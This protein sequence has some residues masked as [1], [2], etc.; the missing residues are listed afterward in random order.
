[1]NYLDSNLTGAFEYIVASGPTQLA[2]PFGIVIN[3]GILAWGAQPDAT[4]FEVYIT[5]YASS[6]VIVAGGTYSLDLT[7]LGLTTG[8][9]DITIVA[10]GDGEDFTDSE[11]STVVQYVVA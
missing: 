5:G 2:T 9:H 1:V 7:A 3:D 8:T 4:N 11:V 6:P 10:I